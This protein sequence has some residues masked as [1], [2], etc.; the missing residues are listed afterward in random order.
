MSESSETTNLTELIQAMEQMEHDAPKVSVE[1]IVNAVGRRSFGPLLLIAGLITLAPVIGDIPGMPTLMAALVLLVSTQLLAGRKTF[2]LPRWL[3][4]R[5]VSR[6]G[7][8]KAIRAM[9][10]PARWV[11]GLLGTRFK[12]MSGYVGIRATA[13]ACLL[14]ALAMPPMEFVPFT[15]NG[16]GLAL[17]LFGLGLVAR[18]GLVL[19]LGFLITIATFVAILMYLL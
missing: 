2:W 18:D 14:V 7:F 13:L 4:N 6:K 5:S 9:K 3:L 1:D 12:W 16:A 17:T 19:S 15:A 10:K 8:D 11:D